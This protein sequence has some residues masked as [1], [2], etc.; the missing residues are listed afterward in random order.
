MPS[1]YRQKQTADGTR[2]ARNARLFQAGFISDIDA[3]FG[4]EHGWQG[5]FGNF[6]AT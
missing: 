1:P 6:C 5:F 4:R 3:F 2:G